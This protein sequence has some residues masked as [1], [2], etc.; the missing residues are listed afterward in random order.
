[1]S[2]KRIMIS[3]ALCSALSVAISMMAMLL[4]GKMVTNALAPAAVAVYA[5]VRLSSD[6]LVLLNNFGLAVSLP[7][8]LGAENE[9]GRRTLLADVFWGQ[10][11]VSALFCAALL[12]V[13]QLPSG[14]EAWVTQQSW[15]AVL[16]YL[17]LVAL[18][19][20]VGTLRDTLLAGLAGLNTYGVRAGAIVFMGVA[21]VALVLGALWQYPDSVA[22]VCLALALGYGGGV[23][24]MCAMGGVP[25]RLAGALPAYANAARISFPLYLNTLVTFFALRFDTVLVGA[26]LGKNY[27][28][29]IALYEMTKYIPMVLSRGLG[30][31]LIPFLPNFSELLAHGDK[32]QALKL[33]TRVLPLITF[34]GYGISLAT[35]L[36]QEPVLRILYSEEYV[37]AAPALG[38]L[39]VGIV[40]AVQAGLMG[41]A[42]IALDLKWRV[43]FANT[44]IA[45]LSIASNIVLIPRFG[46]VGA[47]WAM[48]FAFGLGLL[49]QYAWVRGAGIR[50]PI[51]ALLLP[52]LCLAVA[53]GIIAFMPDLFW[54]RGMAL[55]S[56][57]VFG[58]ATGVVRMGDFREIMGVMKGKKSA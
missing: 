41:Q 27:L 15:G 55:L 26:I 8:M 57:V 10:A 1:L 46:L 11:L 9:S 4:L 44:L 7:K 35:V 58:F 32:A 12:G 18:L 5:L 45:L 28:G 20:F 53:A 38:L 54:V 25:V 56:F 13:H 19:A 3:G 29:V 30:A 33:L 36:V 51:N 48:V 52:Q 37:S 23:L 34:I 24:M 2:R 39:M 40:L 50:L 21:Q 31:L 14:V 22:G 6:F 16:P 43:A 17:W 49:L 47:G 42:L